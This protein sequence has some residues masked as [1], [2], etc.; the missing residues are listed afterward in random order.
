MFPNF[1]LQQI[2]NSLAVRR[3]V[4]HGL[5]KTELVW[6]AFG[7]ADDDAE[8]QERRLRQANL[9][10][11]AGFISMEDGAATGFVLAAT[12]S[13]VAALA[14]MVLLPPARV[15]GLS[16]AVGRPGAATLGVAGAIGLL[17][18]LAALPLGLRPVGVAT[19]VLLAGLA[20]LAVRS[21][22]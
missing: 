16:A 7:F 11:P 19:M 4:T 17:V 18:A 13:R 10:G 1:V 2:R 12:V 22:P 9:M 20:A 3:V 5:E 6:T 21:R 8:M 15:D 14:P